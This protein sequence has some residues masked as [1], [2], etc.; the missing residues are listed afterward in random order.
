LAEDGSRAADVSKPATASPKSGEVPFFQH[1]S[2][3]IPPGLME[4][5]Y[6]LVERIYVS[7]VVFVLEPGVL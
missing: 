7:I 1:W 5:S 2:S 4:I 6:L 3:K